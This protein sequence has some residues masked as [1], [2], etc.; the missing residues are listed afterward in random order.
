MLKSLHLYVWVFLTIL[1]NFI[2]AMK[3]NEI[4]VIVTKLKI[5]SFEFLNLIVILLS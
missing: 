1:L 3:A 5:G 2:V 4:I